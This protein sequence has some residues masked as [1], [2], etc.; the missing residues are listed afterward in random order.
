[1]PWRHRALEQGTSVNA[2]LWEYLCAFAESGGEA[3]L[4][5]RLGVMARASTASSAQVLGEFYVTVTRKLA[6]AAT[7]TSRAHHLSYRDALIIE[8][9]VSGMYAS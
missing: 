3:A 9:A 4:R 6:A 8:A 7:E 1:M 2:L 5:A